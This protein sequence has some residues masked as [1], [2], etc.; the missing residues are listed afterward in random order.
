MKCMDS[1]SARSH[2]F[3]SKPSTVSTSKRLSSVENSNEKSQ[4]AQ[5]RPLLQSQS[6]DSSSLSSP[7]VSH[8][9]H[10]PFLV[11]TAHRSDVYELTTVLSDRQS[12]PPA[13]F[14]FELVHFPLLASDA[15]E[16]LSFSD[17]SGKLIA[18]GHFAALFVFPP[19]S[20]WSRALRTRSPDPSPSVP[21]NI[22]SDSHRSHLN[23]SM[24]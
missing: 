19:C 9:L 18:S 3:V 8:T 13:Q 5:R 1:S 22:L 14:A 6:M 21:D 10:L 23:T 2:G 20:T 4:S 15:E 17:L 12:V 16:N 11:L 24:C 7:S